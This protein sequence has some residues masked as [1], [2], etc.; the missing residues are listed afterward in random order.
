M[1][2]NQNPLLTPICPSEGDQEREV[3]EKANA[4]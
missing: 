4:K 3:I 1:D 2:I